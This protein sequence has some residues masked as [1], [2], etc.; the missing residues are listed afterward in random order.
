M[1]QL[2][3]HVAPNLEIQKPKFKKFVSKSDFWAGA[4]WKP[5]PRSEFLIAFRM[6]QAVIRGE[7]GPGSLELFFE[8]L[9]SSH[10]RYLRPN[11][12]PR[13]AICSRASLL[14]A[15]NRQGRPRAARSTARSPYAS[16]K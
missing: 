7:L 1:L 16:S 15:L 12:K 10:P 14:V 6:L 11:N 4:V 3:R 9:G 13:R 5:M 8:R 2:A